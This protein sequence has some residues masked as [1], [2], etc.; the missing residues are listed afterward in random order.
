MPQIDVQLSV[1]PQNHNS[2]NF[3]V[4]YRIVKQLLCYCNLKINYEN[5]YIRM[6]LL[7]SR[8]TLVVHSSILMNSIEVLSIPNSTNTVVVIS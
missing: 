2:L 4:L 3:S 8:S 7:V 1:N 5:E 6:E